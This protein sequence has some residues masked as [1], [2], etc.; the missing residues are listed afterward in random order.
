MRP[1][2]KQAGERQVLK[3]PVWTPEI[4]LYFYVGGLA[5]ASAGVGLL[6]DETLARRAW[7]VALAGSLISP[8]L[9]IS[10]LGVPTRFLN[11]LRMFKVT[12]PMS[13]GSWVLSGFG[14]ATAPAAAHAFIGLGRPGRAAQVA[15]AALG[16]PLASYTGALLAA[17]SIP[18]WHHARGE[19][20]FLFVAGAAASAGA[21]LTAL[22]PVKEAGP[23]RRL[24]V[25]GALAE[26]AVSRAM[27]RRPA[28]QEA[29]ADVKPFKRAAYGLTAS[30]AGL[31][32]ARGGRSRRAAV[33]GGL[34]L[35]AGAVAER[36]TVFR[37]GRHSARR[38]R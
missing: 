32:A 37:A 5:G 15:S 34:L 38:S 14:A 12:S 20:P 35:S 10:D 1:E 7:G 11:M 19:L 30:G 13:V 31:I 25:G 18:A 22:S 27:E 23:A 6:A 36:W 24:A 21:A 3:E 4:P 26:L 9:L 2:F 29:F 8:A 17:T 33:A 16:L 28:V